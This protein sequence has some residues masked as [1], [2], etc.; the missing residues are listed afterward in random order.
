MCCCHNHNLQLFFLW[1]FHLFLWFP[2]LSY[3]PDPESTYLSLMQTTF[4]RIPPGSD[5]LTVHNHHTCLPLASSVGLYKPAPNTH[6]LY[7]LVSLVL[8]KTRRTYR[9]LTLV[10]YLLSACLLF[11]SL[12]CLSAKLTSTSSVIVTEDQTYN[13][14][15]NHDPTSSPCWFVVLRHSGWPTHWGIRWEIPGTAFNSLLRGCCADGHFS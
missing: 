2:S 7:V 9:L 11:Q 8:L 12:P 15:N 3:K 1:F 13:E 10:I 4:P 14:Q 5:L 6:V